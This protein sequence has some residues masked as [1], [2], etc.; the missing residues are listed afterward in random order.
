[1]PPVLDPIFAKRELW[2]APDLIIFGVKNYTAI[3]IIY[4]VVVVVF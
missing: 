2:P 1:M 3:S 4:A